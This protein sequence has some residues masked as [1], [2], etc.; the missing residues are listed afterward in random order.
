[1]PVSDS[2]NT[3]RAFPRAA[4]AQ[5]TLRRTLP[6][7][8]NLTALSIRFSSAAR[9]RSGSPITASGNSLEMLVSAASPLASARAAS[10][11]ASASARRRGRMSSR[12]STRRLA[13]ARAASTMSEVKAAT[14]SAVLLIAVAQP[15]SRSPRSEVASNSPSARMPVSGVLISCA[16]SASAASIARARGACGVRARERAIR[17]ARRGC[18]RATVFFLG[19]APPRGRLPRADRASYWPSPIMRRMSAGLAPLSRSD[20]SAVARVDFESFCPSASRTRR[21]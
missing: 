15:R 6:R 12:R 17:L 2:V 19:I 20:R 3:S 7:S 4:L 5:L 8:V 11:A 10:E 13:S 9:N 16:M 21:W 14:C 18:L 1:M